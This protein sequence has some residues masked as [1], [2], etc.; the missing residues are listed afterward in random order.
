MKFP[1]TGKFFFG[2]DAIYEDIRM[3]GNIIVREHCSG[4]LKVTVLLGEIAA[5]YEPDNSSK[6]NNHF[7]MKLH[8]FL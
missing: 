3:T 1:S 4:A 8:Y 7:P 6:Y 5:S 2:S